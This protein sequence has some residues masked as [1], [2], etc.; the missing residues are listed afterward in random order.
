MS[1]RFSVGFGPTVVRGNSLVI[2]G[3]DCAG[4][5]ID[6]AAIAPLTLRSRVDRGSARNSQRLPLAERQN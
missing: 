2:R 1:S 6:Q 4:A 5:T 3:I